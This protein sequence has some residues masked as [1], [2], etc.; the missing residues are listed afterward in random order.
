[1]FCIWLIIWTVDPYKFKSYDIICNK[2]SIHLVNNISFIYLSYKLF[3]VIENLIILMN[4]PRKN[5]RVKKLVHIKILKEKSRRTK[6]KDD[7]GFH[8]KPCR[9]TTDTKQFLQERG[10]SK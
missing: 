4:E 8:K 5:L 6:R 2:I 3:F 10:E 7:S 9:A 1:M